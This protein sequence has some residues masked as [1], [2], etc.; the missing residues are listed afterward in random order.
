MDQNDADGVVPIRGNFAGTHV[1]TFQPSARKV[2]GTLQTLQ[3][4]Q[5]GQSR[6]S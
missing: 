6:P 5:I 4:A 3:L 1:L 2:A